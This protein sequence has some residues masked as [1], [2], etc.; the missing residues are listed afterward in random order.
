MEFQRQFSFMHVRGL[1]SLH[2]DVAIYTTLPTGEAIEIARRGMLPSQLCYCARPCRA[3]L[4]GKDTAPRCIWGSAK[5]I[6][7]KQCT[8]DTYVA[9][10]V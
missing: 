2:P 1:E 3:F 10:S 7:D 4:A 8:S 9:K 5:R 6:L